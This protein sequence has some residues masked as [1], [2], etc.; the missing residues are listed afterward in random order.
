[1]EYETKVVTNKQY[2]MKVVK[3]QEV[4]ELTLEMLRLEDLAIAKNTS[5][6]EQDEK[7]VR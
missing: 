4:P 7:E 1:M 2:K 6:R 5:I 3:K